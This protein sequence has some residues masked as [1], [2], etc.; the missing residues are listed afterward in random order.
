VEEAIRSIS[1]KDGYFI[2]FFDSPTKE[3]TLAIKLMTD[4]ENKKK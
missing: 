3:I 2:D 1:F 4:A